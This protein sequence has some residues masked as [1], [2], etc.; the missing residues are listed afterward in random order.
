[1]THCPK[2]EWATTSLYFGHTT[3]DTETQVVQTKTITIEIKI[4]L[5]CSKVRNA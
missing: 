2:H 4:C 1:M 3:V 5:N